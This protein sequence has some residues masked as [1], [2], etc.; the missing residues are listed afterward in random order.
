[1][2]PDSDSGLK[3]TALF[4]WEFLAG[5]AIFL[6]VYSLLV[7]ISRTKIQ[8][9]CR[10]IHLS[11]TDRYYILFSFGYQMFVLK[12]QA[13]FSFWLWHVFSQ[14][15]PNAVGFGRTAGSYGKGRTDHL[16]HHIQEFPGCCEY[17]S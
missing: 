8:D 16:L 4:C 11:L 10:M 5:R 1:M 17:E 13:I 15:L 9:V 14:L 12:G 3:A 2:N 7:G 6:V